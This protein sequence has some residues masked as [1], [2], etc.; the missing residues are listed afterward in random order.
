MYSSRIASL[1]AFTALLSL[2]VADPNS[3]CLS[4]GV[5]F[6][7]DTQYFIN[8]ASLENF[9]CVSTFEGCNVGPDLADIL[10]VDPNGDEYLCSSVATT[11]ANTPVLSTCPILKSQMFSGDWIILVV[12][13]NDDGNPFAW[14]RG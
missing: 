4:S 11:P 2:A 5:D 13:N 3:V 8:T 7:D 14:E 10:L 9:T 1:S 12:G 6:V